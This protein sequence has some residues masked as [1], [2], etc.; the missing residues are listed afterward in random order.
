MLKDSLH[1]LLQVVE[2][3]DKEIICCSSPIMASSATSFESISSLASSTSSL[4]SSFRRP[5]RI[6]PHPD[7]R[8]VHFAS[9]AKI[10]LIEHAVKDFTANERT[11]VWYTQQELDKQRRLCC[12]LAETMEFYTEDQLFDRFGIPSAQR[13]IQ[14]RAVVNESVQC[15]LA[16]S[17]LYSR[18]GG[19]N[20]C[21]GSDASNDLSQGQ[22][23]RHTHYEHRMMK[24][25]TQR[26]MIKY[27]QLNEESAT[28]AQA[29]ALRIQ[30]WTNETIQAKTFCQRSSKVSIV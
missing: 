20:F 4:S 17:E 16:M 13:M 12:Q 7:N 23:Q 10:H 26:I 19:N 2:I 1:T 8:S 14:R 11:A 15:V 21:F 6:R 22:N 5:K 28:L 25:T 29:R 18:D 24:A 27:K 3:E 9:L 30:Q